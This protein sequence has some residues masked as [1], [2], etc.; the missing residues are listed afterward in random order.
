MDYVLSRATNAPIVRQIASESA[1]RL[2]ELCLFS[3]PPSQLRK[4]FDLLQVYVVGRRWSVS[5]LLSPVHVVHDI[6]LPPELRW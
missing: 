3:R 2:P 5:A 1:P 4:A 6:E